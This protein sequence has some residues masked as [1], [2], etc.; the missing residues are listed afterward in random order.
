M[1]KRLF[2]M[3]TGFTLGISLLL[4]GGCGSTDPSRF[5]LLSPSI[6]PAAAGEHGEEGPV[7]E[8]GP[9]SFPDYLDR[10]QMVLRTSRNELRLAEFER[11]AE[12]LE[13]NFKRVL[14]ENLSNLISTNRIVFFPGTGSMPPDFRVA[15]DVTR[16]ESGPDRTV[17]LNARWT[18]F[19]GDGKELLLMRKSSISKPT[20]EKAD[21]EALVS[22][23]SDALGDLSREIAETIATLEAKT[24][25]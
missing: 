12:P 1:M 10:Q 22:A 3:L 14:A 9:L 4:P 11:W 7:I 2:C 18:L 25:G 17:T 19:K 23:K 6:D 24:S 8:I 21:F 20:G 16:F 15:V 5:Y 13:K